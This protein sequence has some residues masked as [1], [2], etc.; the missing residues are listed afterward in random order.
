MSLRRA[1]LGFI[2]SPSPTSIPCFPRGNYLLSKCVS[3]CLSVFVETVFVLCA[4]TF[5]FWKACIYVLSLYLWLFCYAVRSLLVGVCICIVASSTQWI[6][7][8]VNLL[9]D[10][11]MD[12]QVQATVHSLLGCHLHKSTSCRWPSLQIIYS[13]H[14]EH[15]LWTCVKILFSY[16]I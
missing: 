1:L 8:T 4:C 14:L 12:D 2:L 16:I 9:P 13:E 10:P 7:S 11:V 5:G 6:S 3:F 15:I